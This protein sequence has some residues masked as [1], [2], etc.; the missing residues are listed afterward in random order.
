MSSDGFPLTINYQ[1]IAKC[2]LLPITTSLA[3]SLLINPY[4]APGD[5]FRSLTDDEL[6]GILEM[7]DD[8][9]SLGDEGIL[10]EDMILITEM[11][12]QA[13]GLASNSLDELGSRIKSTVMY[14]TLESLR[15]RNLVKIHYQNISYGD[16]YSHLKVAER[17]TDE[18]F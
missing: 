15:R 10:T 9:E 8:N 11:L 18:D 5:F 2:D 13:E 14:F 6:Y 4:L 7:L 1:D 3:E 16:D 17:L 12:V